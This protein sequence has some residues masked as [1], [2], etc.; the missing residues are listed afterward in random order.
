MML[1]LQ[2]DL[3]ARKKTA[4][5]A[6]VLMMMMLGCRQTEIQTQQLAD[7]GLDCQRD[8]LQRVCKQLR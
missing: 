7:S 4:A 2:V 5:F 6:E 8:P 3:S 1:R